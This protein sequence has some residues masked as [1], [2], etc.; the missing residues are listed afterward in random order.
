MPSWGV[1][2]E[3]GEMDVGE[4]EGWEGGKDGEGE[5]SR[6]SHSPERSTYK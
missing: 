2:G 1:G 6:V 3:Q 5:G 4:G